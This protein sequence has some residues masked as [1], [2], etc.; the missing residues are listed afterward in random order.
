[1]GESWKWPH[2][3][4]YGFWGD[5]EEGLKTGQPQNEEKGNPQGNMEFFTEL[6]KDP[7]KLQ[8]FMN[9]MSGIQTG[10]FMAL[11]NKFNFNKYK[12]LL[13]LG[14]ADGWLS[15][16]VCLNAIPISN[17]LRLIC[18]RLNPWQ[19]EKLKGLT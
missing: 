3:R 9:A 13:D 6:Y 11:V 8:E 19:R 5:L 15:I 2:N 12:T 17:A 18:P 16:Q 1:M 14:G 10:N 7:E 4:L